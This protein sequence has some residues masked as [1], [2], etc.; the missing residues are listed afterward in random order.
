MSQKE[1]MSYAWKRRPPPPVK[2]P[3]PVPLKVLHIISITQA[4]PYPE[5][6]NICKYIKW[7]LFISLF[8]LRICVY[9]IYNVIYPYEKNFLD[10][11]PLVS[12]KTSQA[13]DSTPHRSHNQI[14]LLSNWLLMGPQDGPLVLFY[15]QLP[16]YNFNGF[17]IRISQCSSKFAILPI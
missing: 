3:A 9:Q 15:C 13:L 4:S 10:Y 14:H 12:C 7:C 11:R 17:S 1:A 6:Q 2:N 5:Q 16:N 8:I